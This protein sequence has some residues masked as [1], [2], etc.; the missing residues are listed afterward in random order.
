MLH[1]CSRPNP[2]SVYVYAA[3]PNVIG[4][5][6]QIDRITKRQCDWKQELSI[7]VMPHSREYGDAT[8]TYIHGAKIPTYVRKV[9]I[10]YKSQGTKVR[11]IIYSN[12][13]VQI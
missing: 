10:Q 13:K 8:T 2:P 1:A 6:A 11:G 9:S 3:Y 7:Y 5:L 12:R 4:Q